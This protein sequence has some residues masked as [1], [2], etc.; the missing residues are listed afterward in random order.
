VGAVEVLGIHL[1]VGHHE[2]LVARI[3]AKSQYQV[4][5]FTF[6]ILGIRGTGQVSFPSAFSDNGTLLR[7]R[8]PEGDGGFGLLVQGTD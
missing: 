4:H 8:K 7:G 5:L 6:H 1:F 3:A 2:L